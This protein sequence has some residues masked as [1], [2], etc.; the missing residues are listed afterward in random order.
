MV[1]SG[2]VAAALQGGLALAGARPHGWTRDPIGADAS[3]ILFDFVA[4]SRQVSP[5]PPTPWRS[6]RI[7]RPELG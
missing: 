6:P 3:L 2:G 5:T 7:R 1:S 4:A